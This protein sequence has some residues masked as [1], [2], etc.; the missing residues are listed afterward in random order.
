[1]LSY[2]ILSHTFSFSNTSNRNAFDVCLLALHQVPSHR[3]SK[4]A[5]NIN[6]YSYHNKKKSIQSKSRDTSELKKKSNS[7]WIG[8]PVL[9]EIVT[10]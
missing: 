3:I 9:H 10:P 2:L 8:S 7:D 4:L 1:M 5:I 6:A